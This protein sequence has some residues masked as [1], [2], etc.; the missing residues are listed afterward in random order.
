MDSRYRCE[1]AAGLHY[2]A[3]LRPP[4]LYAYPQPVKPIRILFIGW[5]PTKPFGGFWSLDSQDN[6]RSDLHQ[7]LFHLGIVK[8]TNPDESFL[9]EFIA[10]GLFFVH[11]V[12]CWTAAKYPGF[13]E[14]LA[15]L[16]VTK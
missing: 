5:N 9:D 14:M 2:C 4:E 12:K 11:A 8:A 6:L 16:S 7:I 3:G 1:P 15:G 13:V 10:R